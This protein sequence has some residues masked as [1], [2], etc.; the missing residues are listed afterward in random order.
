MRENVYEKTKGNGMKKTICLVTDWYPTKENPFMGHFFK[1][2]VFVMA[3]E[4]NFVIF[5]YQERIRKNPFKKNALYVGNKEANTIEYVA[6]AY[7]P[8]WMRLFEIIYS[9]LRKIK[10]NTIEGIGKYV[11]PCRQRWTRRQICNL[12][13]KT[14]ENADVFYCVDAQKESFFLQCLSERFERPYIIGEHAPVPWP[15]TLIS[16]V[17]KNAMEKA[18]VFLAIS[19]DKI[20]QI[21][22]QN[23]K[24]P[25][26]IYIGNL[27]DER[28]FQYRPLKDDGVKT[29]LIVASHSFYKNYDMFIRV[30][31]RIIE[32][33]DIQ[34]RVLVAG[35]GANKGYSKNTE[36][37]ERKIKSSKFADM[38]ELIPEITH[39]K[40]SNLYNRSDAFVLTSIQEG[41][42]VSAL[43]AACC[44]LPLFSTRCGGIEDYVDEKIGRIYNVDDVEGMAEGL[45]DFLEGKIVFDSKIIRST[46]IERFGMDAFRKKFLKAVN[47]A[48]GNIVE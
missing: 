4:F 21:L 13:E 37:L 22:L 5:R 45:R 30:M 29:L 11:P 23:I 14:S 19:Y 31:D 25:L 7:I 8:I 20:R 6:I 24:L 44:G 18:N 3:N 41:Q 16:D 2:Q 17:N 47:M 38:V 34:F 10:R 32:M 36:V 9:L 12:F 46:V 42:P 35:Y 40:M 43:E 39:D 48:M 26:T 1:E 15:G 27:I 33:T 28:K